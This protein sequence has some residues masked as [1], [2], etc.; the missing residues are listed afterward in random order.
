M[1]YKYYDMTA[2]IRF[3]YFLLADGLHPANPALNLVLYYYKFSSSDFDLFI[4]C[5]VWLFGFF[6]K[7]LIKK[8]LEG[9]N[10][11]AA[12]SQGIR[13]FLSAHD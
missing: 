10:C 8:A 11:D 1:S 13:A 2:I 12:A 4:N 9:Q 3:Y 7:L 5:F 6:I